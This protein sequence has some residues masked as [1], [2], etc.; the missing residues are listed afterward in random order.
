MKSV[1]VKVHLGHN[2]LPCSI[3][4]HAI[5]DFTVL[6]LNGSHSVDMQFCGCHSTPGGS[7]LDVQ[8]LRAG[9]FPA[10]PLRPTIAFTFEL[11]DTFHL[12][13]LQS[14]ISAYDFYSFVIKKTDSVSP[15]SRKVSCNSSTIIN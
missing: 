10:S 7:H 8:L 15:L 1:G 6:D 11:L 5:S 13:T 2:G 4:S 9:L 3:S 14:K 12:L